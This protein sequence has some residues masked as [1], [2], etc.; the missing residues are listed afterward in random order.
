MKVTKKPRLHS[1]S[2]SRRYIFGKT[3]ATGVNLTA[4]PPPPRIPHHPFKGY[5][6]SFNLNLGSRT[7]DL[8]KSRLKKTEALNEEL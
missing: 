5:R 4:P 1:L 2:L 8:G 3:T 7:R 6:R